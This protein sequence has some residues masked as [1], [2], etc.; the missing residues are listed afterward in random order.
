MITTRPAYNLAAALFAPPEVIT[1][2][3]EHVALQVHKPEMRRLIKR[4]YGRLDAFVTV[5][6]TA[7]ARS[8]PTGTTAC[9]SVPGS[10][11]RSPAASAA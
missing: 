2:G 1:I 3:Q 5:A 6:R 9:W 7:P 10:P 11:A 8:S 4:R